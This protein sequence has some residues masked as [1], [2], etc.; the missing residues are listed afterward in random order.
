MTGRA[1]SRGGEQ[2]ESVR[3][4]PFGIHGRTEPARHK[5][6]QINLPPVLKVMNDLANDPAT[7]VHGDGRVEVNGAMGTVGASECTSDRAFE[8]FGACLAKRRNNADG[9]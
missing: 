9:F 5:M 6:T 4:Q 3:G 1:Q 8:R 2:V 7:A